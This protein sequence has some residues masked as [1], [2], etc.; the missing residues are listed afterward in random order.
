MAYALRTSLAAV[1]SVI[2]LGSI[3]QGC[4]GSAREQGA[5][6]T[7]GVAADGITVGTLSGVV[8][9]E[10]NTGAPLVDLQVT[11]NP[12]GGATAYTKAVS[13]LDTGERR[14]IQLGEF[15]GR[16]GASFNRMFVVPRNVVV[17]AADL[18]G[19]KHEV[20]VRWE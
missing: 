14:E 3:L 10:N 7:S 6:G 2:V 5:V 15:R 20:T 17:T 4:T 8:S 1:A 9:V 19:K 13:R 12:V 18:S 16:N 11:I